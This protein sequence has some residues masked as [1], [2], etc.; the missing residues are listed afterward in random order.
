MSRLRFGIGATKSRLGEN[1][2]KFREH[3]EIFE[4]EKNGR[5]EIQIGTTMDAWAHMGLALSSAL[6]RR[7]TPGAVDRARPPH[8]VAPATQE[9]SM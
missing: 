6:R 9:F 4:K 2:N 1:R 5:N 7:S 3:G 8:V